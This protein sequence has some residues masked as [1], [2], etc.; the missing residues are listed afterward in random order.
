MFGEMCVFLFLT[1]LF[2]VVSRSGEFFMVLLS[3]E[4]I[5]LILFLIV[6]YYTMILG[7]VIRGLISIV[8]LVMGV[9]EAS[10]GLG[11]LVGAVRS[12]DYGRRES[13]ICL[14]F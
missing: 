1:R 12:E 7:G 11:L 5:T 4:F 3:F 8:F 14:K 2:I 9:C 10:L 13:K 6:C